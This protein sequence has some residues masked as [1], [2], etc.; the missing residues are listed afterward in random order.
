MFI[1]IVTITKIRDLGKVP[2]DGIHRII[3]EHDDPEDDPAIAG[4]DDESDLD[5]APTEVDTSSDSSFDSTCS[6]SSPVKSKLIQLLPRGRGRVV[7]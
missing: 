7:G 5:D 4:F 1:L 2:E 3:F 6:E